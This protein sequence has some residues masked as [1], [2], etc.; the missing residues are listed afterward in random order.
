M[1]F[2]SPETK[3]LLQFQISLPKRKWGRTLVWHMKQDVRRGNIIFF[4][5][6]KISRND[7]NDENKQLTLLSQCKLTFTARNTLFVLKKSLEHQ[8]NSTMA[9]PPY[10][11]TTK[12]TKA[13][14][15]SWDSPFKPSSV[16][17]CQNFWNLS[18][19]T[20]PL[21]I[22]FFLIRASKP[23]PKDANTVIQ[24]TCFNLE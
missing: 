17:F 22:R 15:I 7:R 23:P 2:F 18:H 5:S 24:Q 8:K 19:E 3:F 1:F 16:N 20:V 21:N 10:R 9:R 4:H 6:P 12:H 11:P 14:S 13:K